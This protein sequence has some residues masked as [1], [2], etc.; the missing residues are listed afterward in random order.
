M[1]FRSAYFKDAE[2]RTVNFER[3]AYKRAKTVYNNL[4]KFYAHLYDKWRFLYNDDI[5]KA[6]YVAIYATPDGVTKEAEPVIR[7]P[8]EQ[9]VKELQ[10]GVY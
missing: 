6:D 7:V 1:L 10:A 2:G 3:Y 5:T 9:F 8:I 4:K